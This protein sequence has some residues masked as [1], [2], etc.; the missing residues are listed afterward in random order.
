MKKNDAEENL[1]A[2]FPEKS[3]KP[4]GSYGGANLVHRR[5]GE[6]SA[7]PALPNI[8]VFIHLCIISF[9]FVSQFVS[10]FLIV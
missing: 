4:K 2:V 6:K 5:P 9:Y 3:Q 10:P 7:A 1:D 8:S